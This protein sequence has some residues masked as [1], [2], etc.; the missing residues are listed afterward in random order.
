M[1]NIITHSGNT[2]FKKLDVTALHSRM[3]KINVLKD[4][5]SCSLVCKQTESSNT[6]HVLTE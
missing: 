3:T 6:A 5:A 2:S 1:F 4:N